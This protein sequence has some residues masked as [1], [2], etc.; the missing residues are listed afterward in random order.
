MNRGQAEAALRDGR[1]KVGTKLRYD[2]YPDDGTPPGTAKVTKITRSWADGS[3]VTVRVWGQTAVLDCD[4]NWS[5]Y[6]LD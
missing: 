6:H 4:V 5:F 1:I 2:G 3:I